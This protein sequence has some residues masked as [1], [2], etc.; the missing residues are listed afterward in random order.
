M[1]SDPFFPQIRSIEPA[2]KPQLRFSFTIGYILLNREGNAMFQELIRKL[3]MMSFNFN[4][5]T[6]GIYV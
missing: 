6:D 5:H 3:K 4:T 2:I 1:T